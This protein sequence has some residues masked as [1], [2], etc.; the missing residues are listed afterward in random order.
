MSRNKPVYP[1]FILI[2]VLIASSLISGL[3]SCGFRTLERFEETRE[4]MGTYVTIIMYTTKEDSRDIMEAGFE[5][6]QEVIDI[7]SVYDENSEM[8]LLNREGFIEDPSDELKDLIGLSIEYYNISG[9][10]FDITIKPVLALWSGGLWKESEEV[11]AAEI[12]EALRLV[13]S[14]KIII[15]GNKIYFTAEGMSAD[16]GGIAKGYAADKALEVISEYGVEHALV[17]AGGDMVAIGKKADGEKWLAELENPDGAED[18]SSSIETLPSFVF[19]NK[20][21]ATSGNYHR[22]YDPEKKVHHI[23]DPRTGY[24]AGQ[25][26]SVTI[27]ADSCTE[28]DV[29]ATSVFVK[30]PV[31]GM[32]LVEKMEG[33]EAL[34]IDN[35][36]KIYK[37]SGLLEYIK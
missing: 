25:C 11:Q 23:T 36:G 30:G 34:I 1:V 6:M 24:S 4:M 8:S 28:A 15:E 18:E 17:N 33:I 37:S 32:E 7:A 3:S 16:L 19:E 10:S 13:G 20:A 27:I 21:V 22:Y 35:D 31:E 26:I 14:D 12:R 2:I 9:G 29:L 5:R